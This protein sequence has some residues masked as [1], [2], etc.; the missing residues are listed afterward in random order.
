M[1]TFDVSALILALAQIGSLGDDCEAALFQSGFEADRLTLETQD[2]QASSFSFYAVVPFEVTAAPRPLI[3]LWPGAAGPGQADTAARDLLDAWASIA[4][5]AGVIAVAQVPT[6]AQ[7]GWIPATAEDRLDA[8]VAEV[9]SRWPVSDVFAFGFSAGGHVIHD[10]AL[11]A[12]QSFKAY[13]VRAGALAAYA[14]PDAPANSPTVVPLWLSV[15]TEDALLPYVRDDVAGFRNAGWTLGSTLAY[16][17]T[18]DGH[19]YTQRQLGDAWT[20]FCRQLT[21]AE[22]I[23]P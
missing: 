6:G 11:R 18:E 19:R 8:T 7:G 5:A 21:D 13:A 4:R 14:G 17:E 3:V 9:A 12:A 2:S 10:I 16:L 15:G 23:D 22:T 1:V 20:F